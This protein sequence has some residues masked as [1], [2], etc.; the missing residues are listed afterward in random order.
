MRDEI[1]EQQFLVALCG[2]RAAAGECP[3]ER[4]KRGR[5]TPAREVFRERLADDSGCRPAFVSRAE[6]EVALEG[7]GHEDRRPFHMYMMAYRGP[8]QKADIP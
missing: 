5:R 7:L 2:I 1:R 8:V 3:D 6:L 4:G